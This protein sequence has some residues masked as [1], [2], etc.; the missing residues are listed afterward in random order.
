MATDIYV[1]SF[2]KR[3]VKML[4]AALHAVSDPNEFSDAPEDQRTLKRAQ[5]L[6]EKMEARAT[7]LFS[8]S[9]SE[10][11]SNNVIELRRAR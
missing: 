6:L 7:K 8:Q 3:E 9:T 5:D 4:L 2:T 11:G 10:V 1:F